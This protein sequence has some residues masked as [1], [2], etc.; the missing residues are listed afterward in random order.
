MRLN[1]NKEQCRKCGTHLKLGENWP[2]SAK[3]KCDYICSSCA[4]ARKRYQN[5]LNE[6]K[7]RTDAR[8]RMRRWRERNPDKVVQNARVHYQKYKEKCKEYSRNYNKLNKLIIV[9]HTI[10]ARALK[11]NQLIQ[12]PCIVCGN[13]QTEMHHPDYAFPLHIMWLCSKHHKRIH[14]WKT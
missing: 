2:P 13:P 7:T 4:T 5:S 3:Q 11:K 1:Q 14:V 8:E 9:A 6:E 10:A 12:Q